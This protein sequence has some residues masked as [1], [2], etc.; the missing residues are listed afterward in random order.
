MA[1][2]ADSLKENGIGRRK[3]E[4]RRDCRKETYNNR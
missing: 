2:V 1:I 4:Q 3:G